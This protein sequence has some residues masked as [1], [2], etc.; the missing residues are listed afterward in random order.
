MKSLLACLLAGAI[1]ATVGAKSEPELAA[2]PAPKPKIEVC[3]VLDTTGSMSGLIEGAKQKIWAIANQMIATKPAPELKFS[4][5]GYRDRGD[6]Y[7]VRSY[8]LTDD[9]D[10]IYAKLQQF[11]ADGGGDWPESVNAALEEAVRRSGWSA[12]PKTL[13]IIYLVGDAPPHMDYPDDTKYPVLCEEA[14]KKGIVINAVQCG[15]AADTRKVWQEIARLGEGEYLAIS[16]EGGMKQIPT[17]FDDKLGELNREIGRTLVP[18]GSSTKREE[19]EQKQKVAEASAPAAA[20][21]RLMFNNAQGKV[22]QGG[23]DLLEELA[24]GTLAPAAIKPESLPAEFKELSP[25][26]RDARIGAL[27]KKR[28]EL[29]SEIAA[30]ARDRAQYVRKEEAKLAAEGK[31]DGFDAK[32]ARS[33]RKDAERKGIKLD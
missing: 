29:Q 3:F 8:P 23:G 5:I 20:S 6:E 9:I 22:V 2:K 13:R 7:V 27:Q 18:Y 4:L 26:E 28:A 31:A 10:S 24:A 14:L 15:G 12:D 1:T 33:F 25:A 21:D 32:V 19:T 16:Q 17:P 11:R 30:V